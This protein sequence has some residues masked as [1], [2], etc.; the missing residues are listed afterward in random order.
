GVML[1]LG[2]DWVA[3]GSMNMLRELRCAAELNEHYFDGYFDDRALWQMVTTNASFAT[4]THETIGML[5]PGYVA[6]IAVFAAAGKA[7]HQ[8]VVDAELTDVVLVMRGGD[9]LYGD[10]VLLSSPGI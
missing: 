3:S 8:A 2:T 9:V 5:K 4:G 10:D 1:A 7:D 6:D